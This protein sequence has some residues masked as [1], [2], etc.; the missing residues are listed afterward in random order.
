MTILL[1]SDWQKYPEAI[2]HLSTRNKSFLEQAAAV[3]LVSRTIPSSWRYT[4]RRLLKSIRSI[5]I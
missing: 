2:I 5:P 1:Q 3:L 4:I